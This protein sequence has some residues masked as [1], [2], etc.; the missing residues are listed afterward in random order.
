MLDTS[1]L[2]L[3]RLL[4]HI[5]HTHTYTHSRRR[6]VIMSHVVE[7]A[8]VISAFPRIQ[9]DSEHRYLL[10]AADTEVKLTSLHKARV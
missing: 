4:L 7:K 1:G 2:T 10:T 5:S 6:V 8:A 9:K 3:N